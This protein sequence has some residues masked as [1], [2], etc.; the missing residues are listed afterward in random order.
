MRVNIDQDRARRAGVTSEG[1]A[2][3]LNAY[4]DGTAVSNFREGDKIIPIVVRGDD[5]RDDWSALRVLPVMSENGE[6]VPLVQVANFEGYIAPGKFKRLDQERTYTVSGKHR[7]KQATEF[8]SDVWPF[9][10]G[11]ELPEGYRIE[12]GGE[13]ESSANGNGALAENLPFA[14]IG[15]IVLLVLQFNSFRRPAI[16]M[17]TIPLVVIG[18]VMGLMISNAFFSFTAL[19]GIFSL[20]GIIVN[21]GIVLIDRIDIERD[22]GKNVHESIIEACL[23]RMRPILMTTLTTILGLI[24]MALF[25]GAMW[26]PMAIVIM[27]GLAVGSILTLGFVPVLYSLFFREETKV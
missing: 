14:M 12:I 7:T 8:H 11:L 24:P 16:I 1:I 18:A 19:L 2:Q 23:A 15:I 26:F 22:N 5:T 10:E 6:P 27:G 21:N 25:G 3:A 20:F 4:F 9:I 13:V 17:L